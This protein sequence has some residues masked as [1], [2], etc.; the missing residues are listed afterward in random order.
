M[1][2]RKQVNAPNKKASQTPPEPDSPLIL[3]PQDARQR[4][5]GKKQR[6][7]GSKKLKE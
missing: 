3:K 6:L 4:L 5:L 1:Q 7:L 2:M